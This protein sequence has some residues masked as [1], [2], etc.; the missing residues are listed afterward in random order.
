MEMQICLALPLMPYSL[1]NL[2]SLKSHFEVRRILLSSSHSCCRTY[3]YRKAPPLPSCSC[4][5][6]FP[7]FPFRLLEDPKSSTTQTR[8]PC[9][10][11]KR[12]LAAKISAVPARSTVPLKMMASSK[13]L[14][15]AIMAPAM[16]APVRPAMP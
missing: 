16:G 3:C 13:P 8:Q 9:L 7:L 2:P 10:L 11:A 5:L 1:T 4:L 6:F 15:R 12:H 14:Y